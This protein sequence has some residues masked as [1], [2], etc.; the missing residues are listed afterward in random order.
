VRSEGAGGHHPSCVMVCWGC[1][2]RGWHLFIFARKVWKLVPDCMKRMCYKELWNLLKRLSSMVRNG[3]SSRTQLLPTRPRR[4]R[5]GCGERSGL[6][7]RRGLAL[8]ESRPQPPDYKL[9]AV[10][11]VMACRK[12]HN[13][14]DILKRSLVKAA[15]EIPAETVRTA[16]RVAGASQGLRRSRGRPFWVTLL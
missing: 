12:R 3:S 5:S 15:A 14:L 8:G 2:I 1:H 9:W 10:L 13:N 6:Y 11:E 4:L 16:I 7:Q